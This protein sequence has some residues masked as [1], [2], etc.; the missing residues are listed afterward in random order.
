M[1]FQIGRLGRASHF[2]ADARGAVAVEFALV[3]ML[4][5]GLVLEALQGGLYLYQRSEIERVTALAARQVMI[6]AAASS[7]LTAAQFLQ[8]DVCAALPSGMSCANVTVDLETVSQA[9]SPGGFY[10][11]ANAD[12]SGPVP[13]PSTGTYCA[14]SPGSVMYLRVSYRSVAISPAWRALA[15]SS[16]TTIGGTPAYSVT[17]YTAFRNEPFTGGSAGC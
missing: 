10:V 9:A 12:M 8:Q 4:T 17:A 1:R 14:G 7:G 15:S 16:G 5:V 11:Y 13:M 2:T 3:G 6:G